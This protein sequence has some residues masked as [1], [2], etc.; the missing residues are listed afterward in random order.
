VLESAIAN[1]VQRVVC[2][3]TDKAV[4][5]IN[6][7]GLSKAMMEKVMVAKS[8]QSWSKFTQVPAPDS[9][10]RLA[11]EVNAGLSLPPCRR[12]NAL[13]TLRPT[14]RR[15][16]AAGFPKRVIMSQPFIVS[17]PHRLGKDE[18][19]RRLKAG[20]GTVHAR[21]HR[22]LI[23]QEETWMGDWLAFRI[24][25]LGQTAS[26]TIDVFADHVRLEV[27]LPWLLD[28]VA[29]R[30]HKVIEPQGTAMLEKK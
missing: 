8:R 27:T 2:L 10:S 29:R 9:S 18:A 4:Y 7:M 1:G 30:V 6:A 23:V 3:S 19:I 25:A 22:F 11:A 16:D 28:L 15:G 21:F 17:I 20:L 5:P 26:G 14:A 13:R 12:Q 24:A